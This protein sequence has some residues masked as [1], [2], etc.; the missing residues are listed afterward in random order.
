LHFYGEIVRKM[1]PRSFGY[2]ILVFN[3]QHNLVD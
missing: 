3:Y 2:V 1:D